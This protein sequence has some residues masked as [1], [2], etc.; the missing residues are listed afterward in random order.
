MVKDL[1]K[2]VAMYVAKADANAAYPCIINQGVFQRSCDFW[3]TLF[4]PGIC[5]CFDSMPYL[6][7]PN[8][9]GYRQVRRLFCTA[10]NTCRGA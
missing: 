5:N 9:F 3:D 6:P 7:I 8:L 4:Y 10:E 1:A 2:K